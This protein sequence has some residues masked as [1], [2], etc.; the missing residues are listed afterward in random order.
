MGSSGRGTSIGELMADRAKKLSSGVH[1]P[2]DGS[3]GNP[4]IRRS[5]DLVKVVGTRRLEMTQDWS[6]LQTLGRGGGCPT[7]VSFD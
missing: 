3:V 5:E 6:V 2:E 7:V 1:R 4:P